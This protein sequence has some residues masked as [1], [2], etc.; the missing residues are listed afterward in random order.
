MQ[1]LRTV[2]DLSP[3][4][5]GA[6]DVRARLAREGVILHAFSPPPGLSFLPERLTIAAVFGGGAALRVGD[7]R[8]V[9][10]DRVYVVVNA[11]RSRA[12][13]PRTADAGELLGVIPPD[14]V[15][16]GA[17]AAE[18][19]LERPFPEDLRPL[20]GKAEGFVEAAQPHDD[21]VSPHLFALRRALNGGTLT[22]TLGEELMGRMVAGLVRR[23]RALDEAAARIPRLKP[24]TRAEIFRRPQ[25]ARE[26]I[27]AGYAEIRTLAE[28]ATA[29]CM[30]YAH[31]HRFFSACFGCTPHRY[32]TERRLAVALRELRRDHLSITEIS[33]AVGFDN[34][35]SFTA[36][37]RRRF[38]LLPSLFRRGHP[39][40]EE[41][42]PAPRGRQSRGFATTL[43]SAMPAA[44]H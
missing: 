26:F 20:P 35:N 16:A 5:P 29:A 27:D 8:R 37:F 18:H 21:F 40:A 44:V 7:Q 11:G 24:G 13:E 31:F 17:L 34:V 42:L 19:A 9:L 38:G 2:P 1:L 10:H 3:G 14:E 43:D 4:R 22:H 36:L 30:S 15:V 33:Y 25:R 39:I 12:V 32:L 41:R 6:A 23:D 28:V